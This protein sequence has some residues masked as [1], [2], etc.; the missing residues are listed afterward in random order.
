ME[1]GWEDFPQEVPREEVSF[2]GSPPDEVRDTTSH[3]LAR[4]AKGAPT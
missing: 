3:L 2:R 1:I 4:Q